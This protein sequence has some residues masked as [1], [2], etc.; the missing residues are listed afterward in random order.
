MASTHGS[1]GEYP[2]PYGGYAIPPRD[3]NHKVSD[4]SAMDPM[5]SYYQSGNRDSVVSLPSPIEEVDISRVQIFD[6]GH[7]GRDSPDSSVRASVKA[8]IPETLR[9]GIPPTPSMRAFSS[10]RNPRTVY[11]P[12]S[13]AEEQSKP[14]RPQSKRLS[15]RRGSLLSMSHGSIPEGE[16]ISMALLGYSSPMG[17][18]H[19]DSYTTVGEED[20]DSIGF[21]VSS[22]AGP[23]FFGAPTTEEQRKELNMAESHGILTGGLGAGWKPDTII[24]STDLLAN[25]PVSPRMARSGTLSRGLSFRT[26]SRRSPRLERKATVRE[27]GQIEANK[28][29]KVIEVIVEE[30]AVD[31][32]SLTGGDTSKDVDPTDFTNP[33]RKTLMAQPTTEVFYPQANWKPVSMRWPYISFLIIISVVLAAVQEYLCR[34]KLLYEF[35]AASKLSTWSY[36]SFKYLP[37]LIAVSYG[38]LW[39]VTDFEVKRLEP[40]YQLSKPGGALAAESIN[41]DYSKLSLT[42]LSSLLA[43]A[44]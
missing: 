43:S 12:I 7:A 39:Q 33:R 13:T 19:K 38:V 23:S 16:E 9:V 29:G 42:P 17:V 25:S 27:L 35:T 11:A 30:P 1:A 40:Y 5:D 14:K 10:W 15:K 28:R 8:G 18:R 32:S 37:T 34:R 2:Y 41:V 31:I 26:P 21:D 36:F 4:V 3:L 24:R 20:A 44:V 22:Y 6:D